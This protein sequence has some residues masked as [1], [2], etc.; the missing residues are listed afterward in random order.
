MAGIQTTLPL[1]FNLNDNCGFGGI[2]DQ[3]Q[4]ISG[5]GELLTFTYNPNY[6][7]FVADD[8][9]FNFVNTAANA[10]GSFVTFTVTV[11]G[12]VDGIEEFFTLVDENGNVLGTTEVGQP[13]VVLTP[14]NCNANPATHGM[15]VTTLTVPV[16]IYNAWAA[17]GI[18]TIDAISNNNF[19]SPPPGGP[20][21]GINPS[22]TTFNIGDPDGQTDGVSLSLIHI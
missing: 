9:Q 15:S 16:A 21:D 3:T 4:P 18:V 13:N 14:G 8:T 5:N 1:P 10:A 11:I 17:D 19:A 20:S 22:C 2:Y 6:L 12:D 7:D